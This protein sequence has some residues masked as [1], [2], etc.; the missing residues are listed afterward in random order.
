MQTTFS[1]LD[2][3]SQPIKVYIPPESH[4][5]R[6]R[7]K[8]SHRAK[9]E[10]KKE[11]LIELGLVTRDQRRLF[12]SWELHHCQPL[13]LGG[14]TTR[15]NLVLCEP[16]LHQVIHEYILWQGIVTD[17]TTRRIPF[18]P[19]RLWSSSTFTLN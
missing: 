19:C 17:P 18:A 1:D 6:E 2:Y 14:L 7:K 16:T 4:R 12:M 5:K 8:L 13:G 11:I 10:L 9:I 15:E 3:F